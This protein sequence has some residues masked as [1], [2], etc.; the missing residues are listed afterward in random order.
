MVRRSGRRIVVAVATLIGVAALPA[1]PAVGSSGRAP[2]PTTTS[3]TPSSTGPS[4]TAPAKAP[5]LAQNLDG[6]MAAS[7]ADSCLTVMIDGE[8]VYRHDSSQPLAPASTEKLLTATVALDQLGASTRFDTKVLGPKPNA[9][10]VISGDVALVGGGDPVLLTDAHRFV[11][12]V[13][14]DQPYTSLDVLADQV[15]ASG[16]RGISGQVVGDDHRYDSLRT[17]PSWPERYARQGQSGPIGALL[18]DRGYDLIL[19]VAP[20]TKVIERRADDPAA[21]AARTF[22]ALLRARGVLVTGDGATGAATP[23][24]GQLGKV[25]SPPLDDIIGRMLL[26]SDNQIAEMLTKEIGVHAGQGGSTAAGVAEI[27]RRGRELGLTSGAAHI[28]DG[29]GLDPTN[30]ATCDELT[31]VLHAS[32]GLGGTLGDDLPV[33]GRSGTLIARF[34][35]NPAEGRLHAKTGSLTDVTALAGF[36][37]LPKGETATFAYIANG[38]PV[39]ARVKGA[40]DL[41]GAILGSYVPPCPAA[42]AA[43]VVAPIAPYA[44]EMG[45]LGMF[46]LQSVLLPGA[47][48]PLHVFEDRYRVLVGRCV[49]ADEDFGVVLISR[50]SEV[51]GG[52]VRT[53]VGTQARIVQAEQAD[54]G[55]W[56]IL[57]LGIN[58]VRVEEWLPDDPHPRAQVTDWPDPDPGVGV[59]QPL[60]DVG[61]QLR[62]VLAMRA[63]LGDPGP[64]PTVPMEVDDPTLASFHLASLAPL[65]D[66]DR[67]TLL[68]APTIADRL[69]ALGGMLDDVEAICRARLSGL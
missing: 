48:L 63:E 24:S 12:H 65:G 20:D 58:R 61:A 57:A 34:R 26:T 25:T 50:G 54:D 3:T 47:V 5:T 67:H 7:P 52:D 15:V 41:L 39:D 17:V 64:S 13:G 1:S 30:R 11:K 59:D 8:M 2:T 51:G 23:G 62:R 27:A 29:S 10:G 66:L 53:D 38:A 19:P 22:T 4:S 36:V 49:A 21:S 33:A 18:V 43:P 40:Q 14:A 46:P 9:D 35:G 16:V 60:T 44:S 68:A 6:V 69:G 28:V 55:R 56:G 45:V 42:P 37:A 31:K 32:G